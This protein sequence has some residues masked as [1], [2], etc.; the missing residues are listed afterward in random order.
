[1][2]NLIEINQK[3][4]ESLELAKAEFLMGGGKID[5]IETLQSYVPPPVR[6]EPKL[7][8][9]EIRQREIADRIRAMAS[10]L[11]R[12][13]IAREIGITYNRACEICAKYGIKTMSGRGKADTGSHP[14]RFDPA[15]DPAMAEQIEIL[16]A[17]G[18]SKSK[19]AKAI[20]I[21]S[22]RLNRIIDK[23]K[24]DWKKK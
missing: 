8:A 6:K 19:T 24:I 21:G 3:H 22:E 16:L 23:Y 15:A 9:A 5:V 13:E 7:S 14:V 4:Q 18:Y 1:M 12:A 17:Q 11:N 2:Q 20:G 10:K